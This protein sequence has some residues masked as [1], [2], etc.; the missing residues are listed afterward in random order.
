MIGYFFLVT[1][2]V[3]VNIKLV[4]FVG[5]FYVLDQGLPFSLSFLLE[6][7]STLKS[8]IDFCILAVLVQIST[9]FYTCK[10]SVS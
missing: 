10:T 5:P 3:H 2:C 4:L 1:L 7:I 9:V 6:V 8:F